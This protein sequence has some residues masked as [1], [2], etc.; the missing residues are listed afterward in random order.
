MG[1][2]GSI[3]VP[4]GLALSWVRCVLCKEMSAGPNDA[5]ITCLLVR[6]SA[7][8]GV[9]VVV[10]KGIL[11]LSAVFLL[12]STQHQLGYMQAAEYFQDSQT[13]QRLCSILGSRLA[14]HYD[15]YRRPSYN[16][17]CDQEHELAVQVRL[18]PIWCLKMQVACNCVVSCSWPCSEGCPAVIHHNSCGLHCHV[19]YWCVSEGLVMYR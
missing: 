9:N 12:L 8:D 19:A 17:S 3:K 15:G 2:F 14:T 18:V 5:L 1:G 10:A 13:V 4:L 6:L 11:C 16:P 7:S